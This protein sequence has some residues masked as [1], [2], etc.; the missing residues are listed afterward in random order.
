M[1][2]KIILSIFLFCVFQSAQASV[3]QIY[4]SNVPPWLVAKED[5][6]LD[7]LICNFFNALLKETT[8]KKKFIYTSIPRANEK[9]YKGEQFIA[10]F[11]QNKALKKHYHL[12]GKVLEYHVGS[13]H[14]AKHTKPTDFNKKVCI[15]LNNLH[16]EKGKIYTEVTSYEQCF[17]M[18]NKGRIDSIL[19]SDV[20]LKS[21]LKLHLLNNKAQF[22]FDNSYPINLWLY[23][24]KKHKESSKIYKEI[25]AEYRKMDKMLFEQDATNF[26]LK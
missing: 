23:L 25:L 21:Y 19:I 1:I 24:N 18:L 14:L 4:V 9:F 15:T 10:L 22:V 26:K 17:K 11:P 2:K 6:C 7:G 20:E 3:N 12:I 8:L 5:K 13:I 16:K